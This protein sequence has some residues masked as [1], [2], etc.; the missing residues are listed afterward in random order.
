MSLSVHAAFEIAR[1]AARQNVRRVAAG[2][3][4]LKIA[5][6]DQVARGCSFG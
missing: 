6:T 5:T 1:C 2:R 3:G 4:F